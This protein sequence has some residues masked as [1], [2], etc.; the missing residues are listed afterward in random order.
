MRHSKLWPGW[1][2]LMRYFWKPNFVREARRIGCLGLTAVLEGQI[3]HSRLESFY[4][5]CSPQ[6]LTSFIG[7][8]HTRPRGVFAPLANR[9]PRQSR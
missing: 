4:N 3:H 6:S 5:Y 8:V 7:P 9:M 2:L 1:K